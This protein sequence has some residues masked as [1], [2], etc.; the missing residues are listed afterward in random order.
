V[1]DAFA[2]LGPEARGRLRPVPHPEWVAPMLATLTDRR[3]SDPA[4]IFERKLDGERCLAFRLGAEVRLLSRTR[5]RLGGTYPE[6][7]DAIAAQK[8]PQARDVVL[9]GEVVA[10]DGGNTSFARLQQ[11]L[12]ITDPERARRSPVAVYYYVFDLL[13]LDGYDITALAVRDRKALLRGA[14]A[15]ADPLRFTVHRNG[16]GEAYLDSACAR[17]WEGLVAK[18]ATSPYVSRRSPDWL[19]LKC[20]AS[21][22]LVIGGFTEPAGSRVGLGALLVGYHDGDDLVYAGKVGTG[23]SRDVLVDLR[24]RLGALRTDTAPFTRG[25]VAER[26]VHWV[27]PELVAQVAF[28]EW[29]ADGKLRHPRFE[30]L[31]TDKPAAQVTRERPAD[32]SRR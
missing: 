10:F 4:W 6:I 29:T 7:V 32:L 1:T 19:K 22:E 31:R 3:F 12:G 30:G 25:G 9:D 23:F 18:R 5:Q 27:R 26:A 8:A 14:L 24:R 28:T 16:T 15:F 20:S 2:R 17:G 21:Q 13:H 11:R